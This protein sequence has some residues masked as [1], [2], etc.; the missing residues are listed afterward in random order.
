MPNPTDLKVMRAQQT[1]DAEL[2]ARIL[3]GREKA[4]KGIDA[5]FDTERLTFYLHGKHALLAGVEAKIAVPLADMLSMLA[6][7]IPNV[8]VP[9]TIAAQAASLKAA[10]KGPTS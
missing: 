5:V 1:L 4:L 6:G 10:P 8:L 9:L 2:K 3:D 7:V